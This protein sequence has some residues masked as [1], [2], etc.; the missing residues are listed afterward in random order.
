VV[1]S[2]G[3]ELVT[4]GGVVSAATISGGTLEI[5]SGGGVMSSTITFA[6]GGTLVL[7]DTKF[8]GKIAGFAVPDTIDLTT[9]SFASATLGYTGNTL[10]GTFTVTDSVH[11]AKLAMLGQ[12]A[13]GNHLSDDGHGG[14]L[15]SDPP[16]SSGAAIAVP[17]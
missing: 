16:V 17:H 2:G 7:D 12:Y 11:T 9:V 8:R 14:T 13:A 4:S 15:V 6:S 3:H 5:Q 1:D 10:S